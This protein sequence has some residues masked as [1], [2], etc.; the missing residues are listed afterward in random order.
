VLLPVFWVVSFL[1]TFAI[2][3]MVS[4]M[5]IGGVS[6]VRR[7][8]AAF[9]REHDVPLLYLPLLIG[10]TLGSCAAYWLWQRSIVY[11][12]LVERREIN[13]MTQVVPYITFRD[14]ALGR[15]ISRAWRRYRAL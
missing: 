9:P 7:A 14:S 15:L 11:L 6:Y 13:D 5:L 4:A 2:V 10:L 1:G 12:H 3:S 8:W